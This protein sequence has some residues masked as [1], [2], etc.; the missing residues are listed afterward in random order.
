M[1]DLPMVTAEPYGAQ[2][3][4]LLLFIAINRFMHFNNYVVKKKISK[5]V[6]GSELSI[7]A[8]AP[9]T[10]HSIQLKALYSI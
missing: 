6:V 1:C 3:L 10:R 7:W 4:L 9:G 2:L 5:N 8:E